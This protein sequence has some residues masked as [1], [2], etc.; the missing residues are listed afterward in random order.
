MSVSEII[1]Q[2][3]DKNIFGSKFEFRSNQRETI[4]AICQAYIDDPNSTVILDAPTGTG[5][6]I[7]AMWCAYVLKEMGNRG[8]LIT[9]DLMLQE[10]YE[11][12]IKEFK[13]D[14]ASIKGV[15]L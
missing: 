7:I 8:Y 11:K 9:S 14:W 6:S 3:L 1:N 2:A 15:E 12:D 4:E 5:K 13:L 10:Q